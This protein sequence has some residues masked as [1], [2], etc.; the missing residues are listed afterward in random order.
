MKISLQWLVGGI[1]A[2]ALLCSLTG[3][4]LLGV[5]A[6]KA[7][8]GPSVSARYVPDPKDPMLVLVESY[9]LDLDSGIETEH[10]QT[11]LIKT[12][13]DNK[14]VTTIVDSAK[15]ARLRDRD[16]AAY[17]KLTVDEIGR[18]VGARQVLYVNINQENITSPAGSGQVRGTLRA[19]VRIVDTASGDLRWP[20]DATSETV[21][22]KTP[23]KEQKDMGQGDIRAVMSDQ[24]ADEIGKLFH[25]WHPDEDPATKVNT[26]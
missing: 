19:V 21:D 24:M 11:S 20:S 16:P 7:S 2:G 5:A 8:G 15:V 6:D 10:V 1:L 17:K 26:D 14:V 9:G 18:D 23:W 4:E 13:N 22:I 3:C 12:L 25:D